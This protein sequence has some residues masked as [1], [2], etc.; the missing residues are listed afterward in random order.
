M[1]NDLIFIDTNILM[2][3]LFHRSQYD[4]AMAGLMS[5]AEQAIV[6]TSIVSVSTLL[7]Y[8][9][10][11]KLDKKIAHHFIKGYRILGMSEIDYEWAENNDQGDFEDALQT[12]CARRHS[13]SYL[14]TLDKRFGKMYGKYLPVQTIT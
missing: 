1:A 6:C 9:E 5:L 13:C 7:Y 2:E 14:L 11:K 12:A 8:V 3:V 4:A 10:A